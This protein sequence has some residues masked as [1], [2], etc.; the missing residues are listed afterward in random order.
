MYLVDIGLNSKEEIDVLIRVE[1][2]RVNKFIF[3]C[4]LYIFNLLQWVYSFLRN[5]SVCV[6]KFNA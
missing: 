1:L 6:M 2:K 4:I 3:I 5:V